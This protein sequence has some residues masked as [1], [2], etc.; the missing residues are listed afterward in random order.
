VITADQTAR[1]KARLP[2]GWGRFGKAIDHLTEISEPDESLL[3]ACV[4]LNPRFRH[5]TVTL[6]GGLME[7]TKSTNLVLAVTDQRLI[8]VPTGA[9][10]A[11]RGDQAIPFDGLEI[12]EAAKKDLTLR[13]PEGEM[14]RPDA[15]DRLVGGDARPRG[16]VRATR[17]RVGRSPRPHDPLWDQRSVS[18]RRHRVPTVN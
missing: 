1:E 7:L 2:R 16:R 13:L 14:H 3:S 18:C 8:L 10:G 5:T 9:G 11:P 12:V 15:G 17:T 4:G 6:A